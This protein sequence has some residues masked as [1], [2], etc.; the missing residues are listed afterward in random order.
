[1]RS[2]HLYRT[3]L[4]ASLIALFVYHGL[5]GGAYGF[6][7]AG[8]YTHISITTEALD[9]YAVETGNSVSLYCAEVLLQASVISDNAEGMEQFTYHCDNNDLA[10]CSY[11][12]DQFKGEANKATTQVESLLKM[13]RAL[14]IV[15]DFYSHS[16][17][18]E[19]FGFTMIRAPIEQFKDL[20]PPP[21]IQS[22]NFPDIYPDIGAQLACYL[23]PEE[24]WG[25]YIYGATHACMNKDSN[26]TFRGSRFYPNSG[27]TYHQLAGM[28]AVNHSV[29][30]LKYYGRKNPWFKTCF[31]PRALTGG[32][33]KRFLDWVH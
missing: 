9:R 33:N 6:A 31:V 5:G 27:L 21:D 32:C 8:P 26:Q 7:G 14:H 10:G 22:G 12:L 24:R 15:Q 2:R 17:W 25:S 11:R 18:V 30:L 3:V 1:M 29:E 20:R 28:Y 19:I 4:R 16:N 23:I 13:G